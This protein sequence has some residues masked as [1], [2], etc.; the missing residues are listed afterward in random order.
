VFVTFLFV[1]NTAF[2][3]LG[4]PI[5]SMVFNWGRATLGTIPFVTI[6]AKY[7]GF[8]GAMMGYA[9][10]AAVFGLVSAATAYGVTARLAKSL[11]SE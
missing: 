9:A 10:G 4:F 6:G 3:N 1:A 5:L 8:E 2:N 7:G 11:K